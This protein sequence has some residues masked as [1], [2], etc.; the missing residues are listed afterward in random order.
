MT[1]NMIF[2]AAVGVILVAMAIGSLM[3]DKKPNEYGDGGFSVN[4]GVDIDGDEIV[5]TTESG[6]TVVNS[7]S[8]RQKCASGQDAIVITRSDGSTTRIEC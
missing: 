3:S 4:V 8:G 2:G 5:I 7:R 6:K 1:R